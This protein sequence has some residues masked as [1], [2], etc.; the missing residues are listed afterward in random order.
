MRERS[1]ASFSFGPSDG[2]APG[3]EVIGNL[4]GVVEWVDEAFELLTGLPCAQIVNKP[5]AELLERAGIDVEVVGFVAEHFLEGRTCRVELP[6]ERPDG[7]TIEVFLEV[8]ALRDARG[9]IERFRALAREVGGEQARGR[10]QPPRPTERCEAPTPRRS[11]RIP[12]EIAPAVSRIAAAYAAT[13][14]DAACRGRREIAS[15]WRFDFDFADGLAPI[16]VPLDGFEAL[17]A[18]LLRSAARSID[19][20]GTPWGTITLVT[21]RARPGRRYHSPAYPKPFLPLGARPSGPLVGSAGPVDGERT[22]LEVHDTG[23]S[24]ELRARQ[25]AQQLARRIGAEI[26]F[27]ATPGCGNQVIVLFPG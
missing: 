25:R 20:T 18:E 8:F 27:D 5:V 21:G 17:V 7:R 10:A 1:E 12:L 2:S 26:H 14:R 3:A 24:G 13:T 11:G 15:G 16:D 22:L 23:S 4:A 9:E 19:A 6:F